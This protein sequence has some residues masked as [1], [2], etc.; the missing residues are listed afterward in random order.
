LLKLAPLFAK[1]RLSGA[2]LRAGAIFGKPID[3]ARNRA[4][5]ARRE[6]LPLRQPAG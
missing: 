3:F 5:F 6:S 4:P 2:M 1:L